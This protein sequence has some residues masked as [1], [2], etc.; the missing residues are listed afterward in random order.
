MSA[1]VENKERTKRSRVVGFERRD[2]L[3]AGGRR[4]GAK[5]KEIKQGLH[6]SLPLAVRRPEMLEGQRQIVRLRG[7]E[8]DGDWRKKKRDDSARN[9]M[10][11]PEHVPRPPTGPPDFAPQAAIGEQC[12]R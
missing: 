9:P 11:P 12:Q 8:V 10:L 6:D 2:W 4:I 7:N 1:P 3:I 5:V